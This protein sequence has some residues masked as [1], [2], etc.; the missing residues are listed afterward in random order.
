MDGISITIFVISLCGSIALVTSVWKDI[1]DNRRKWYRCIKIKGWVVIAAALLLTI[2]PLIQKTLQ[3]NK[4]EKDSITRKK[5]EY[6]RDSTLKAKYDS[7]LIVSVIGI[8]EKFDTS[9]N[10]QTLI[11]SKTLGEYGLALD[12]ANGKIVKMVRDSSKTRIVESISPIL[13]INTE[14]GTGGIFITQSAPPKYAFGFEI[15]SFDASSTDFN[16]ESKIVAADSLL[17][18]FYFAKAIKILQN[19]DFISAN[20]SSVIYMDL[21]LPSDSYYLLINLKGD[22]KNSDKSKQFNIDDL[23]YYNF[24]NK[25]TGRLGPNG[26]TAFNNFVKDKK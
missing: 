21:Y 1:V 22:Y 15:L 5:Q 4:E 16:I 14:D 17:N 8:K 13:A 20:A 26:K 9:I 10:H 25:R 6:I 3:D 24:K 23:Y 19:T 12:S 11:L 7:S 18:S 2:F